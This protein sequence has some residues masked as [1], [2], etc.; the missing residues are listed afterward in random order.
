MIMSECNP[1][2]EEQEVQLPWTNV[3]CCGHDHVV[4]L[5]AVN[6]DLCANLSPG[7][8][9]PDRQALSNSTAVRLRNHG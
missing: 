6:A 2:V 3:H 9:L 5:S 7:F 8:R 4:V 1:V